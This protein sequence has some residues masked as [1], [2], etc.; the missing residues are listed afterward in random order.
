MLVKALGSPGYPLCLA[1]AGSGFPGAKMVLGR[2][3]ALL[4]EQGRGLF[5]SL[6]RRL[7]SLAHLW[8][9]QAVWTDIELP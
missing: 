5:R 8:N 9:L 3:W 6:C 7:G 2:S 1:T 4:S